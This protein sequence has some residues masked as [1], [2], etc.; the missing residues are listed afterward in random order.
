M[1]ILFEKTH[2][3]NLVEALKL[4]HQTDESG[5]FTL[6][7]YDKSI[8]DSK[9]EQPVVLIFDYNK[10]GLETTTTELYKLGF[11]IFAM[12][13]KREEKL[14]FFKLSLTV[15]NVWPKILTIVDQRKSA[16]VCTYKYGGKKLTL[17]QS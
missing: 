13:T 2:P 15:L 12:K 8:D 17:I 6:S 1:V 9:L 14:D 7:Y 16:F 4:I 3:K 11:R 5:S 10:K